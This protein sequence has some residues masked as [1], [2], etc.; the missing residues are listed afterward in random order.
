MASEREREREREKE[1]VSSKKEGKGPGVRT[2]AGAPPLFSTIIVKRPSSSM[3][4]TFFSAALFIL[5]APASSPTMRK[6]VLPDTL[7]VTAPPCRL[8]RSTRSSRDVDSG[9]PVMTN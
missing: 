5:L 8:M 9:W 7:P 2:E 1:R 3:A 4:G 6:D